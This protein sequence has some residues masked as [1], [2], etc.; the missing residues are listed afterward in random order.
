MAIDTAAKRMSLIGLALPVPRLLPAPDGEIDTSDR[1]ALA[2]L[3]VSYTLCE[4]AVTLKAYARSFTTLALAR[5]FTWKTALR[6][7][8]WRRE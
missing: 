7:F 8:T 2:Y 1:K 3:Y 5:A 4:V 6:S